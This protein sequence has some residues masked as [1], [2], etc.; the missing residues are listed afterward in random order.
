MKDTNYMTFFGHKEL[1]QILN[2]ASKL[3]RMMFSTRYESDLAN[4]KDTSLL[5]C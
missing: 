1:L 4:L 3:G 5:V 2:S